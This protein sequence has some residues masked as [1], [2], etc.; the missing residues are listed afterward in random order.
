MTRLSR[1]LARARR[2]GRAEDGA[3]LADFVIVLPVF[4]TILLSSFEAGYAMMRMVMMERALDITVRDLRV[5]ALNR[6]PGNLPPRPEDVRDRF[7][8]LASL[9][10]DCQTDI[11]LEMNVINRGVWTGFNT[12]ARCVDRT[13]TIQPALTFVP[14][15]TNQIVTIRA[16][17]VFD[18]FFPTTTLGLG[19]R[20]DASGGYQ[21]AS[22]SAFVNEP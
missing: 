22:M 12:P 5:G 4:L 6:Q 3:V 9:M 20:R 16:C 19:L 11:A 8:E 2:F 10:P 1:V 15:G 18:P 13:Q 17:A 14:G 7:C 21:L